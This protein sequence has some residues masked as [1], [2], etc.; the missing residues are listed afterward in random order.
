MKNSSALLVE[1]NFEIKEILFADILP[2]LGE[3]I[4]NDPADK[5]P[6]WYL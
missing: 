1:N 3:P 4:E 2:F 6:I 5:C